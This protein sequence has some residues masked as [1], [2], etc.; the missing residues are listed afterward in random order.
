VHGP[1]I[2]IKSNRTS[3]DEN[4]HKSLSSLGKNPKL[5][6]ECDSCHWILSDFAIKN[7]LFEFKDW[8]PLKTCKLNNH[9]H[10]LCGICKTEYYSDR[11]LDNRKNKRKFLGYVPST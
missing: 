5:I 8:C 3:V 2:V 9:D 11:N 6:K 7:N 1:V 10:L 4:F